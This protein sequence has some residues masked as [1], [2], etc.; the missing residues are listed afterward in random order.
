MVPLTIYLA[1]A[2]DDHGSTQLYH[3]AGLFGEGGTF[4]AWAVS[5]C[6]WVTIE[7][8]LT[9]SGDRY[10]PDSHSLCIASVRSYSILNN[11]APILCHS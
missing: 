7:T 10:V 3:V 4:L 1:T 2:V 8:G 9:S 6:T 11:T 5:P